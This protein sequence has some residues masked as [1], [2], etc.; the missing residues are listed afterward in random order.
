MRNRLHHFLHP[1]PPGPGIFPYLQIGPMRRLLENPLGAFM[2]YYEEYGPVY[3][4]RFLGQEIVMMAGPEA[5]HHVLVENHRNFSWSKGW[6]GELTPFIGHGLLTT[7]GEDHDRARRLMLPVFRPDR[8]RG[9]AERMVTQAGRAADRL[10]PGQHVDI[11]EWTR[12]LA[13]TIACDILFGID[14]DHALARTFSRQFER[15]LAFYAYPIQ[16]QVLR[17]PG[18][19]WWHM[20]RA[21][22]KMDRI[23]YHEIQRR[24]REGHDGE[25]ILDILIR[26]DEDGD[27]FTDREIRDQVMTLLFAGHD[28]TTCTVSWAMM[29]LGQHRS[30]YR[31]LQGELEEVLGDDDPEA[32]DLNGGLP[33]L[34]DVVAETLRLYPPAWIGP[35]RAIEDFEIYGHRIPGNTNVAYSSWLTHR[36]PHVFPDPDA[37]DPGR[38]RDDTARELQPG[39]YVPFGRGPRTCIGMRFGEL[40]VKTILATLLQRHHLE[41]LPGQDFRAHTQPTIS[42]RNGVRMTI[43]PRGHVEQR[44]AAF[45]EPRARRPAAAA[46]CPHAAG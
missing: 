13:L 14:A 10:D 25:N 8:I 11:Y 45:R 24:R 36:L 43:R 17:G 18:T 3:T 26:A 16:L 30:P 34:E 27:R 15:G 5:N 22:R 35:R 19:P 42:P 20:Q 46:G 7:D 37:F 2:R 38:W 40:E 39:A 33:W 41:L 31:R 29:L 44:I 9:Y 28:T 1:M 32:E 4:L 21:R 23:L 6:L 12:R